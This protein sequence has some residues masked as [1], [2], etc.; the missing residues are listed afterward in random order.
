MGQ[1]RSLSE[2]VAQ[3]ADAYHQ[4]A[5]L[6]RQEQE[7]LAAVHS[8]LVEVSADDVALHR[9]TLAVIGELRRDLEHMKQQLK[10]LSQAR[11]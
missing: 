9:Q 1:S 3:A 10:R 6:A 2:G 11:S 5:E 4:A 7:A 8:L